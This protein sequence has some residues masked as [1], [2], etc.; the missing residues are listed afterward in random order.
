MPISILYNKVY[1]YLKIKGNDQH[2]IYTMS[3][4]CTGS[5]SSSKKFYK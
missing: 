2:Y 4:N 1:L 5:R 3:V